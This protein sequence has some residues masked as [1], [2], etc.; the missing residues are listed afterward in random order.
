MN[1][2][3]NQYEMLVERLRYCAEESGGCGVCEY[4][5][6]GCGAKTLK[7]AAAQALDMLIHPESSGIY[8]IEEIHENCTVE[9]WKNS[10]TGE[11]SIGW[12]E[13]EHDPKDRPYAS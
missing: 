3:L 4:S 5:D 2:A 6:K 8:D 11:V 10:V 7:L 12:Y 1:D 13:G 9:I